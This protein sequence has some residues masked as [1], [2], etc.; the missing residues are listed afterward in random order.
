MAANYCFRARWRYA[1]AS[2]KLLQQYAEQAADFIVNLLPFGPDGAARPD[3]NDLKTRIGNN[4]PTPTGA[5][6]TL[7]GISSSQ[8]P[9]VFS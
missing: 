8:C 6:I 7:L 9:A 3:P 4:F 5:S 2:N 1:D